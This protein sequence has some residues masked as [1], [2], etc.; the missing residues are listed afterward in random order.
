MTI[1]E[2]K[3]NYEEKTG[4]HFFD[5]ETLKYWGESISTMYLYKRITTVTDYKGIKHSCYT[6][7][8]KQRPQ[9]APPRV[10]IYHFDIETFQEVFTC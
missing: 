3:K 9:D 7:S 5:P 6:I 10:N 1:Y 8:V 2:L 4:G